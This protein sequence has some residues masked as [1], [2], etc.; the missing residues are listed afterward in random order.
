MIDHEQHLIEESRR[1][2]AAARAAWSDPDLGPS[3]AVP[4]CE[5]WSL[6]DLVWHLTEV[7]YFWSRIVGSSSE[8]ALA[9]PEDYDR[10]PRPDDGRL[11]DGFV[12]AS[13]A[14]LSA[15][16]GRSDDETCW[17]WYAE[18]GS[19]AWVRRRQAQ[20]AL[21]HRVDAESVR[22]MIG[23][24]DGPLAADGVDEMLRVM[25]DVGQLPPWAEFRPDAE[26]IRLDVGLRAWT[27]R[28]GRF[29]GTPPD[30]DPLDLPALELLDG[31]GRTAPSATITGDPA[32]VDLWLWGRGPADGLMV[33]GDRSMVDRLRATAA[34]ATG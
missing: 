10:P 7:Q 13:G 18:G 2:L 27:L 26:Q 20:E 15:L 28:L 23:P 22:G 11:L 12:E 25:L 3:A 24:I 4:T 33:D 19:I 34:D 30:G 32:T 8:L 14:L 1:F 6:A 9:G 29:V 16:A 17:S 31:D 21:I 5:G